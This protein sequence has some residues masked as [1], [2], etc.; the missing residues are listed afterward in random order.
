MQRE[1]V[2]NLCAD[3][4]SFEMCLQFIAPRRANSVLVVVGVASRDRSPVGKGAVVNRSVFLPASS[5]AVEM[6]QFHLQDR[7]LQCA[8]TEVTADDFVEI[9]WLTAVDA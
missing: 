1:R 6:F 9:L 4:G 5:P 7:G 2:V 3:A 8:Q